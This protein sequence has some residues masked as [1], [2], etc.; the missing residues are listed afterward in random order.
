MRRAHGSLADALTTQ[1][2]PTWELMWQ[3]VN[4]L[5]GLAPGD[6]V[7]SRWASDVN[8]YSWYANYMR[9]GGPPQPRRDG[10]VSAA[11]RL[12]GL[13]KSQAEYSAQRA[14]DDPLVMAEY[15]MTGEAFAGTVTHA[16]P[17]RVDGTGRKRV[18]RPHITIETRDVPTAEAGTRLTS[19][20]RPNQEA[21]VV[22]VRQGDTIIVVLELKG[23]MG[24]GLTAE[25]GSVPAAGEAVC[26]ATF[27][28]SFHRLPQFPPPEETPWTHGG[29]PPPYVPSDNDAREE[30]S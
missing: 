5:R 19:P 15:R 26:Y 10:A 6:H 25:P 2:Q 9:E 14:F 21:R 28:D 30:W 22:D 16:E 8:A 29:P 18:L 27:D 4:L 17:G 3:A 23:G 13:E 12:A 20:A 1:L 24:R 11:R 7:A